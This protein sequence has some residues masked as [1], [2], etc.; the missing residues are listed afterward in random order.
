MGLLGPL[1]LYAVSLWLG[2]AIHPV[3][4]NVITKAGTYDQIGSRIKSPQLLHSMR[5]FFFE[6][7][8][9]YSFRDEARSLG[10]W[11]E[12]AFQ[13]RLIRHAG[14]VTDSAYPISLRETTPGTVMIG[15]NFHPS[16]F[17]SWY[18]L[19][20]KWKL[21]FPLSNNHA[22]FEQAWYPVTEKSTV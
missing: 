14:V 15:L 17:S 13:Q 1:L 7:H 5:S 2:C 9:P 12:L 10:S 11:R 18:I 16:R 8:F 19:S 21:T 3:T 20:K 6:L 22:S 4:A